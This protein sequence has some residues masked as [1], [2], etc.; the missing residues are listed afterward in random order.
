M[1][2]QLLAT[3][4]PLVTP[5]RVA[6]RKSRTSVHVSAFKKDGKSG[7][8]DPSGPAGSHGT[9]EMKARRERLAQE[10]GFQLNEQEIVKEDNRAEQ[11][12]GN[13]LPG[14]AGVNKV[15]AVNAELQEM[16][17]EKANE[18]YENMSKVQ[19]W[20][21][22]AKNALYSWLKTGVEPL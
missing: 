13:H 10:E 3:S 9:G 12:A 6:P 11:R 18:E 16:A 4:R 1:V 2:Q 14:H 21:M 15:A 20:L 19:K 8:H 17:E 5:Q 7:I 22:E